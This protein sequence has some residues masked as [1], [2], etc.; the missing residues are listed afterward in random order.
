[1][2][3]TTVGLFENPGLV[4]DVVREIEAL[5][6][7]RR[8][9]RSLQEPATF[10]VTG[11]MSFPRLDFEVD[12]IRELTRIGAT[13]AEAQ[14]YVARTAAR[15]GPGFRDRFGREGGGRGGYHEPA[16]RGGDRRDQWPRTA[17][18]RRG[19]REHDSGTRYPGHG[20][21][22]PPVGRRRL[23]FRVVTKGPPILRTGLN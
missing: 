4:D 1:M 9:V 7:P 23:P 2:P 8:E 15:R 14:A 17:V 22:A 3:K 16:R 20:W 5:G 21:A 18:T 19:S 11:V 10:E 6:F 12:S 13:K